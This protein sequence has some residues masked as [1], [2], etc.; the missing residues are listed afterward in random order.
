MLT[1]YFSQQRPE[2]ENSLLR[3]LNLAKE[4]SQ[5]GATRQ[6]NPDKGLLLGAVSS[7]FVPS[8]SRQIGRLIFS[9]AEIQR[10]VEGRA[11]FG[12]P[13]GG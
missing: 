11:A 5:Y 12:A 10:K 1:L 13:T 9:K 6:V 3:K 2:P 8:L 7:F 4:R